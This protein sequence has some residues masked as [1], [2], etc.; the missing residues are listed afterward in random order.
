ME[1]TNAT[2]RDRDHSWTAGEGAEIKESD[3][4]T[5]NP[6]S[7]HHKHPVQ[8]TTAEGGVATRKLMSRHQEQ[9]DETGRDSMLRS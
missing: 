1:G 9:H 4:A 2:G 3:V 8:P 6:K 7:R 5:V